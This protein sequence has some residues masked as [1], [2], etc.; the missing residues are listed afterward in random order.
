MA[1]NGLGAAESCVAE[2]GTAGKVPVC[3][4]CGAAH[5]QIL[6]FVTGCSSS[7]GPGTVA[8]P[9]AEPS[10]RDSECSSEYAKAPPRHS[11]AALSAHDAMVA[12]GPKMAAAACWSSSCF[13]PLLSRKWPSRG[14][15]G[16]RRLRWERR[17]PHTQGCEDLRVGR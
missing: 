12:V 4:G 15:P 3:W 5:D 2:V 6:P 16:C 13:P 8:C 10:L 7:G 17:P 9:S 11:S 14:F 1:T